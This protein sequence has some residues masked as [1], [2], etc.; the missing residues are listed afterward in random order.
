MKTIELTA[1]VK[2]NIIGGFMLELGNNLVDASILYDLNKVKAQF[3][4]NDFIYKIR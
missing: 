1:V 2:E 3:K 4:K